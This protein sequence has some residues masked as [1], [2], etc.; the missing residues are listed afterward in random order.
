MAKPISDWLTKSQV[1]QSLKISERTVDR[2]HD[3][4]QLKRQDR[5]NLPVFD[6]DDMARLA[7]DKGLS[8]T[9]G[10]ATALVPAGQFP[11]IIQALTHA[12]RKDEERAAAIRKEEKQD[13]GLPLSE[14]VH[15]V[16]L[17]TAEAG[18]YS[19]LTAEHLSDGR[20]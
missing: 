7:K 11:Q 17:T 2:L 16:Y 14:L 6:P 9:G 5:G 13:E 1:S 3:R 4:G 12:I 10:Q 20:N 15:K 8:D 18:R 19:G